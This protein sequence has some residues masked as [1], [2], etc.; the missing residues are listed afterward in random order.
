MKLYICKNI[1]IYFFMN[2]NSF[3]EYDSSKSKYYKKDIKLK[4]I[5]GEYIK[6]IFA[7]LLDL[8][9]EK[10]SNDLKQRFCENIK[11][12][13]FNSYYTNNA[14]ND[15]IGQLKNLTKNVL[16]TPGISNFLEK[17]KDYDISIYYE[18]N[19]KGTIYSNEASLKKIGKLYSFCFSV[20]DCLILEFLSVF[21][22]SFNKTS[23]DALS[24]MVVFEKTLKI[25][26]LSLNDVCNLIYENPNEFRYVEV[27]N[28]SKFKFDVETSKITEPKQFAL[29]LE[30]F[31]KNKGEDAKYYFKLYNDQKKIRIYVESLFQENIKQIMKKI[32]KLI[33]VHN[34]NEI[35]LI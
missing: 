8:V 25:L 5:N 27:E 33:E 29:E 34:N 23:S 10:L 3:P 6:C 2:L 14:I 35:T 26:N 1:F 11:I 17:A 13:I 4:M 30:E 28:I 18:S 22:N 16:I 19:G 7:Q 12:A 9:I 15:Y 32:E 24:T 21:L 20:N 31:F